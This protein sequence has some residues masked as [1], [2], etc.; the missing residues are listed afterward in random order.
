MIIFVNQYNVVSFVLI[1]DEPFNMIPKPS[2]GKALQ[3]KCSLFYTEYRKRIFQ[4][5]NVTP[6]VCT[7]L[8]SASAVFHLRC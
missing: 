4:T 2:E 7:L 1:S 6:N 8:Q 3:S 5:V